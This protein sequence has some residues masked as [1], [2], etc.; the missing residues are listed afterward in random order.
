MTFYI[1]LLGGIAAFALFLFIYDGIA[2]RRS[3]KK[4]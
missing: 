1:I 2:I 3:Q 4:P